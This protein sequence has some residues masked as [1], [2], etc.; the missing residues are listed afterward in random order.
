[1]AHMCV[2][3]Y[4][5]I[6]YII[7]FHFFTYLR[8]LLANICHF[9]LARSSFSELTAKKLL[10]IYYYPEPSILNPSSVWSFHISIQIYEQKKKQKIAALNWNFSSHVATV[11]SC[12][13]SATLSQNFEVILYFIET[14]G[15][16]WVCN[17]ALEKCMRIKA[18]WTQ[19]KLKLT[20]MII[21]FRTNMGSCALWANGILKRVLSDC[22]GCK[23][24]RGCSVQR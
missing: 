13:A 6:L 20:A 23:Q 1:M 17:I 14:K 7:I 8:R 18:L 2:S 10:I 9:S 4:P 16:K 21:T 24:G 11:S 22:S 15:H 12:Q 19:F 5:F 3:C